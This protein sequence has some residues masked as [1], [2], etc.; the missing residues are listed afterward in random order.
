MRRALFPAIALCLTTLTASA[1][2]A[3]GPGTAEYP[4][5][6][7][8]RAA[9]L[10]KTVEYLASPRLA[11]RLAGSPGYMTAAHELAGR[12]GR[13]GLK[14]AGDGGFFQPLEV[15]YEKIERCRLALLRSDGSTRELKLGPDFTARGLTG[16]GD[17][18]APVVFAGYGISAPEQGYD[19]YA[20]LD[21]RGKVVLAFKL[22]PPF[23]L[24]SLGWGDRVLQRPRGRV[25][26][27]HGARGLLLVALGDPEGLTRPIGS[28]LEGPGPQDE[29]FPRLMVDVPVAAEML[30]ATGLRLADL[31]A[32]IDST[33]QPQSRAL[34]VQVRLDVKARY[35][36]KQPSVNVVGLLEGA[37]PG[38][39]DQY[40]VIGAHLDH[41]GSQAG[42]YF[43]GANDNASGAAAVVAIAE[44]F[45]RGGPPPK[46]SI[47]FVLF[48]SEESGLQG[49]KH[50][51]EQPPVPLGKIVAYLNLDC[52]AVGDS[53]Q[54]GS[55]KTSPKLWR[56]ARDLDA[57]GARL[58]VEE[59]WG[60]GGADAT[61]FAQRKIPT[62]YFVSK[63]SYTH[64]H[65]PGDTPATLN[66][67]LHEALTCLVYRTAW[68][69]AEG[70]YSGE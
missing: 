67:G 61:P 66:P 56:L 23:R 31:K 68:Q 20:G 33:R 4:G 58:T 59:T 38:L 69:V 53:I 15:E 9:D 37:D 49:A 46:R 13:M 42:I 43:P 30:A 57:G 3:A 48:S 52:V 65:Q 39:R 28:V 26:A 11:G 54:V 70:G 19:D 6:G 29:G 60:G 44:A 50:F 12:F 8:I 22:P 32:S 21:V 47:L 45:A 1:A 16:T 63:Y 25:A 18:T 34:G 27:E 51:V 64:L 7:T 55:G 24:D 40:L 2:R 14:P 62:I 35:V 41:V 17:F 5:L 10:M 36:A